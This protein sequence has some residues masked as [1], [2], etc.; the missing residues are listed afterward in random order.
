MTGNN[1]N[2]GLTDIVVTDPVVAEQNKLIAQLVQQIA[3]MRVEIQKIESCQ[4]WLSPPT[5]RFQAREGLHSISLLQIQEREWRAKEETSKWNMKEEI[6]KSIKEFHYTPDVAGLNYEDLCIHPNLDLPERFKVPKFDT[7]GGTG[8]PLAYL[9]AYCDQLVGVG[10]NEAL[11][12]QLF[13]RSLSGEALE[14]FS[15]QEIKQWSNWNALARDFIEI[16]QK[17]TKS[18][19]EY[20]YRWRKEAARVRPPMI[21]KEI[22]EVFVR[23]Q[24]PEYYERLMLLVGAKF[25]EIVNVG[26][27]IEDGLKT[28][29][30]A[31]VASSIGS[32]GL[33]KKKREDVSTISYTPEGRGFANSKPRKP[34][35]FNTYSR[36]PQNSHQ[37]Y[38]TQSNYQT[39]PSNYQTPYPNDQVQFN[40]YQTPP[41]NYPAPHY[42]NTPP[43]YRTPQPNYETQLYPRF[44]TP[45]PSRQNRLSYRHMPPPPQ[46]NYNLSQPNFK[47]RLAKNFNPLV[48]SRTQLFERLRDAGIIHPIVPKLADTSSRFF[49]ADKTFAYHSNSVGHDIETCINLKHKIQDLINR[50]VITLQTVAP[51]VNS[52]P[53]P[54]HGGVNIN[55]IEMEEDWCVIKAI[56]PTYTNSLEM[57]VA[58]LSIKEKSNFMILTPQ[59]VVALVPKEVP[60]QKKFVIETVATQGMTHSGRCYTPEE[61]AQIWNKK[62][63]QKRPISE[64]EAEEFWRKMQPKKYSIVKYLEKVLA[65]ILVWALLMRSQQHRHALMK[66]LDDTYVPV[67]TDGDN[68]AAMVSRV[69]QGHHISFSNEEL[70]FEGKVRQNQVN[71]RAFDGGQRNT[72]GAVNLDIQVGPV[73]FI[74]E[75]Q[76]MDITASYNLL[77]GRPWIHM[78]GAVPSTL[79]QMIKFVKNDREVVIYGEGRHS[80]SCAS[81]IDDIAR[82]IDFYTVELVNAIDNDSAPQPLMPSVYKMIATVML[83]S[84]DDEID[85]TGRSIIQV[86]SRPIPHLYL[87]FPVRDHVN[88]GDLRE[89]I[90]NLF[91][92]VD[93]IL[94]EETGTSG[95]RDAKLEEQLSNWTSAL[96]LAPHSSCKNNLKPAN[97]MSCHKL[98]EQNKVEGDEFKDYDEE[99]VIPEH[100]TE[101]LKQFEEQCK[102]NQ[103]KTEAVNL[104]N[105]ECIKETRISVHLAKAQRMELINLLREYI[106]I[107]AWSYDDVSGFSKDIISHKLS[108][109]SDCSPVKQKTRKFKP[110]LSLRIKKEVTKQ[111]QS[112]VVEVMQYLTWLAN[113][114]SVPKKDGKIRICVDYRDL[115]KASPKDNFPLPNIHILIDNCAKHEMQSFVDSYAG[116]H[117]ILIDEED[118]EKTVFITPWGMYHYRVMP[119]GLKNAGATYMRAMTTIFH[120]MIHKEIKVY[121]DDVIIKSRKSADYSMHL[122]RLLKKDALTEWTKECQTAF[123]AIKSYLSNPPVLVPPREGVLLLLYLSVSDNAF[124]YVLGQHDETGKKE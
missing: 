119:F 91:E 14:W 108:I 83:Q 52:N 97:I 86:L 95:I 15:A 59:S 66:A 85:V 70:P 1:D 42:Q 69:V 79:H 35:P 3:E 90:W 92:E 27:T 51:N 48:E 116:Y 49:R 12:M 54:N 81:I 98:N 84:K 9:R 50:E 110:T 26:E 118:E 121:V 8:N 55:M 44:Q 88:D 77:L 17:S 29:K 36:G 94:E 46:N 120:D 61:L 30:V 37:V 19:R 115:N 112:K 63:Q 113:I 103:E 60:N 100:L 123:D 99:A 6:M 7:F 10:K 53:L 71:V 87:S 11:L 33:V 107:F 31:R 93:I 106:D 22:M 114:I 74:I 23:M 18:Y 117:Q 109:S 122:K 73:D 39:P 16:E 47:N 111:I 89:G 34:T 102:P 104:G 56:V 38:Y 75:C 82:G 101:E 20:A 96:L 72:L 80:N 40:S 124:G 2:T 67:G 32:S 43:N 21:E 64:A 13:S 68:L 28:G 24:E 65:Q 62:D 57:A 78:A 5:R 105:D 76:V 45:A 41:S 25:A 4:N 58:S